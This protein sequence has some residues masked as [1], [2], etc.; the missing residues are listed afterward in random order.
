MLN[1]IQKEIRRFFISVTPPIITKIT[2]NY[3]AEKL[4]KKAAQDQINNWG[5]T[6]SKNARCSILCNG[7]SLSDSIKSNLSFIKKTTKISVNFMPFSPHF[8]ELQPEFLMLVDP[9]FW[10]D[11]ISPDLQ[12]KMAKLNEELLKV[13]WP[14]AIIMPQFA[15]RKNHI[16]NT[17][18]SNSHLKIIF[19]NSTVSTSSQLK[20]RLAEYYYNLAAPAFQSVSVA[21]IYFALNAGYKNIYLF[22]YDHDWV[23]NMVVDANNRLCIKDQHFY[24]K[25]KIEYRPTNTS[26]TEEF[27][28]QHNLHKS[29]GELEEYA[30]YLEARV[31]NA[32]PNGLLDSFEK[33]DLNKLSNL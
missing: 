5:L 11:K 4:A 6:I 29:Y 26:L 24:D 16:S 27:R 14:L 28:A 20:K 19:I 10:E 18:K 8:H 23:K 31:F 25:E 21:S 12:N 15:A 3:L 33:I 2:S 13:D 32:T 7:P 1:K 22:G 30:K 9:A 17:V